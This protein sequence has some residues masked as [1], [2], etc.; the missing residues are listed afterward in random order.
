MLSDEEHTQRR[1]KRTLPIAPR[2]TPTHTLLHTYTKILPKKL[3]G[4][5]KKSLYLHNKSKIRMVKTLHNTL[6][7]LLIATCLTAT[8]SA[9]AQEAQ[10]SQIEAEQQQIAVTV[11]DATLRV[12]NAEGLAIEIFSLTGEKVYTQRI[13]SSSKAIELTHLQRGFYIVKIGKYTRKIY[14]R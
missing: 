6:K 7:V 10:S 1:Q 13:D 14:L 11:S 4:N 12:K 8:A 2:P 3:G 9:T 5:K